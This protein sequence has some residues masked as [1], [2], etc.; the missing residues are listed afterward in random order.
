MIYEYKC[1]KH[2]EFE[3]TERQ[4]ARCSTCNKEAIRLYNF[5]GFTQKTK[6]G[7]ETFR[8]YANLTGLGEE[9]LGG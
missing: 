2:G 5:S 4:G 1:I 8:E 6:K 7:I 3:S 9:F